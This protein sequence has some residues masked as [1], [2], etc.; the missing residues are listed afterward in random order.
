MFSDNGRISQKQLGRQ[1]VLTFLGVMMMLAPANVLMRDRNGVI[2]CLLGTAAIFIY[3]FFIAR[4]AGAYRNP[5]KTLGKVGSK[6]AAL[7]FLVYLILTGGYLVRTLG[8]V[9]QEYLLTSVHIWLIMGLIVLASAC[10]TGWNLQ[11]RARIAEKSY[12]II[13]GGFILLLV[14]AAFQVPEAPKAG[15]QI[16]SVNS[17]AQ[18]SYQYFAAFAAVAVIPFILDQVERSAGAGKRLMKNIGS[19]ALFTIA[20]LLVLQAAFGAKGVAF[21]KIPILDLMSGVVLP[22][23]FLERFDVIWMSLLIFCFLFSVGSTMFY[24]NYILEKVNLKKYRVA[25]TIAVFAVAC[26]EY[27]GASIQEVY[28]A[29]SLYVYTPLLLVLTLCMGLMQRRRT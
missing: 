7:I 24:S 9:V 3:L 4:L 10:G 1:T 13:I 8:F 27:N 20:G 25:V 15:D 5:E 26:A 22:G 14:M 19:V 18:G 17:V 11:R 2:S 23:K 29:I 21:R 6:I 28:G 16:L 12:P